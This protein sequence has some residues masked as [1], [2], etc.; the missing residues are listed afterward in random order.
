MPRGP[1][2]RVACRETPFP[3]IAYTPPARHR[4]RQ[5]PAL[6][7]PHIATSMPDRIGK[8]SLKDAQPMNRFCLFCV[9]GF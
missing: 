4:T 6:T 2:T 9:G 1:V 5:N 3:W 8:S 7:S